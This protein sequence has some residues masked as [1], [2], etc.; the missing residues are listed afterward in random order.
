MLNLIYM[1]LLLS[2][3]WIPQLFYGANNLDE[4]NEPLNSFFDENGY[5]S[6]YLLKNL[7]STLAF[8]FAYL[9]LWFFLLFLKLLSLFSAR[10]LIF[11]TITYSALLGYQKLK[12]KLMWRLS[13]ELFISQYPPMLVASLI[14]L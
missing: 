1:D 14:N 13:I 8:L 5:S 7:G 10:Y 3:M 4:D 11:L 9:G 12:T 2:E 6:K